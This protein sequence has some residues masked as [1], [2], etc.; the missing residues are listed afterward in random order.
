M[1]A[2]VGQEAG[3]LVVKDS[4][5]AGEIETVARFFDYGGQAKNL[6]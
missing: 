1:A 2:R 3:A 5:K 6:A 4:E